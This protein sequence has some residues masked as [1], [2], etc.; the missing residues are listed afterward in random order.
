MPIFGIEKEKLTD[1][2]TT[3]KDFKRGVSKFPPERMRARC[4]D[5]IKEEE[6]ARPSKAAVEEVDLQQNVDFRLK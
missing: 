3:E 2:T 4:E 5:L 6:Q 1:F